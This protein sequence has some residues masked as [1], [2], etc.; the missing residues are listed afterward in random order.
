MHCTQGKDRTGLIVALVLMALD[1]PVEAITHDYLLSQDGLQS[2]RETRLAEIR[3][4]GLTPEWA[5]TPRDFVTRVHQHVSTRY[6][7]IDGYLDSIEFGEA[8]RRGL[9]EALG[10]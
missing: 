9:V 8:E 6:N 3:E 5:D 2:E 7:G 1:V 10:A 4:I